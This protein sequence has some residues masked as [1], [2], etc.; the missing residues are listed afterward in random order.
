LKAS[1]TIHGDHSITNAKTCQ[2]VIRKKFKNIYNYSVVKKNEDFT[3]ENAERRGREPVSN[4]AQP[5]SVNVSNS[6][7]SNKLHP[8]EKAIY[9]GYKT[10]LRERIASSLLLPLRFLFSSNQ[11][12]RGDWHLISGTVAPCKKVTGTT[13]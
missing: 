9:T 4:A 1:F 6:L 2:A 10:G 8:L 11:T 3:A 5:A 7:Y 13:S 12:E